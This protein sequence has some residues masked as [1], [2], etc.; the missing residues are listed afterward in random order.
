[1]KKTVLFLANVSLA[2]QGKFA[3]AK[4]HYGTRRIKKL[5]KRL[6]FNI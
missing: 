3:K 6:G 4:Q 5:F 1:L 2:F